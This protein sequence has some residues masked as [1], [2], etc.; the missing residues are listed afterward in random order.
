V[1]QALADRLLVREERAP[2]V[3]VG[4]G[5]EVRATHEPCQGEAGRR[6]QAAAVVRPEPGGLARVGGGCRRRA[7]S[8][9]RARSGGRAAGAGRAERAGR[10]G[11]HVGFC[12]G[13]RSSNW[14]WVRT[15]RRATPRDERQLT[16]SV[17]PVAVPCSS[18][19]VSSPTTLA[20]PWLAG[21]AASTDAT[22]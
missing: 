20:A 21:W 13:T 6:G 3:G 15:A 2:R 4:V 16:S 14:C 17:P 11:R 9:A 18:A 8:C 12:H 10:T 19:S 5:G 7:R 22:V 1:G